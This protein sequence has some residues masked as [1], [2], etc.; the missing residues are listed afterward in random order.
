MD[1]NDGERIIPR[2]A[3]SGYERLQNLRHLFAYEHAAGLA[4]GKS[5]L[6]A[7]FGEGYGAWHLAGVAGKVSAV[8][9]NSGAVTHAAAAYS[10]GNLEFRL[11][12]G[13]TL[14][15]SDAA[16]DLAVAFQV[17]EHTDDD[18]AF[19]AELRRVLKPGGT[20]LLTTPN[21]LHR[22]KPGQKP[23]YKFHKRE[24]TREELENLLR[25]VFETCEVGYIQAPPELFEMELRVARIATL[26]QA[27]RL[28]EPLLNWLGWVKKLIFRAVGSGAAPGGAAAGGTGLF[29]VGGEDERGLDLLASGK[30]GLS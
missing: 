19:L 30:K 21:R 11:Y 9:T 15:F 22:L 2:E 12:D 3:A 8:D 10:A 24:Y 5:V 16:F 17:I 6:E 29:R 14:P 25:G 26:V 1:I 27:L 4:A 23:W 7:G 18:R 28:P 13:R 20:C